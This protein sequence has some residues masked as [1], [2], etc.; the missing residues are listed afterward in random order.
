MLMTI[1]SNLHSPRQYACSLSGLMR[2]M[3]SH[4][5]DYGAHFDDGKD[6]LSLTKGLDATQVDAHDNRQERSYE[7]TLIDCVIPI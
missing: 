4:E 5:A 1:P 3:Y 7:N 2:T 6:K